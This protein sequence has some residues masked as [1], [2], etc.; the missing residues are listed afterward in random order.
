MKSTGFPE[1]FGRLNL[2]DGP[3]QVNE[4]ELGFI[5]KFPK[6]RSFSKYISRELSFDQPKGSKEL[7]YQ[8]SQEDCRTLGPI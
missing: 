1:T 4:K 5:V 7:R 8:R 3:A 6:P 2:K